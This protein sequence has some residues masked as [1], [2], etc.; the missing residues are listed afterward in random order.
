MASGLPRA[1]APRGPACLLQRVDQGTLNVATGRAAT[2]KQRPEL[3]PQK[4]QVSKPYLD[5]RKLPFSEF[6]GRP[7]ALTVVQLEQESNLGQG[8][9]KLLSSAYEAEPVEVSLAIATDR[10][11]RAPGKRQQ[12]A[13]VIE[14]DR[15]DV[16]FR[17]A[18]E[19]SYRQRHG[20][21]QVERTLRQRCTAISAHTAS[22]TPNGHAP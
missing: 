18:G 14:A 5:H 15:L 22:T 4:R 9:A 8:E 6:T 21:L 11:V 12:S 13:A 7:A 16:D 10:P 3:A 17:R 20:A 19:S 1:R 2:A